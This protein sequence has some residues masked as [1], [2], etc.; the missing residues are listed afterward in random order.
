M[1]D[2]RNNKTEYPKQL[3]IFIGECEKNGFEVTYKK[4]YNSKSILIIKKDDFVDTHHFD[5]NI[6]N[7]KG[8]YKVAFF[9]HYEM[10]LQI[11]EL[12]KNKK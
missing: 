3:K 4:Q 5:H 7:G 11:K 12:E 1:N 2:L 6:I 9:K 10:T 8:W